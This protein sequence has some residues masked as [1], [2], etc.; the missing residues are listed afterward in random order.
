LGYPQPL[1]HSY[2]G[3]FAPSPTGELHWGSLFN[4]LAGFLQARSQQG[5]WL[6]RIDDLDPTRCQQQ[7]TDAILFTLDHFGLHWDGAIHY[8]SQHIE[9]YQAALSDLQHNNHVYP[10]CCSRRQL[11]RYHIEYPETPDYPG[12]CRHK[13]VDT[14]KRHALRIKIK[15]NTS[16]GLN[17][18]LQGKQQQ[19]LSNTCGDFIVLRSDMITAYHLASVV[20]DYNLGI[21]QALRGYDLLQSSIQQHYLQQLLEYPAPQYIHLPV[22]V[23]DS[24]TKLSKQ[25][26][27]IP[28]SHNQ[29]TETLYAL[30]LQLNQN[31]PEDLRHQSQE[32]LLAW[33]INNWSINRLTG[34]TQIH[35]QKILQH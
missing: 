3:R 30:L 9:S 17:D 26:G 21:T 12:L 33:A 5:E 1:N 10:C 2:R 8:Q 31:P 32:T 7:S 18:P 28:V 35:L 22:I 19:I 34:C 4:A 16:I 6:L 15:K 20:D 13:V 29:P 14:S 11:K 27:A 23:D 25:T 24:G